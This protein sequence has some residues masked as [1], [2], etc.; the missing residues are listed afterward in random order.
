MLPSSKFYY[1][2]AVLQLQAVALQWIAQV[3]QCTRALAVTVAP[4]RGLQW[5]Q[6]FVGLQCEIKIFNRD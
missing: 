5:N 2:F 3:V 1:E 6:F 4:L